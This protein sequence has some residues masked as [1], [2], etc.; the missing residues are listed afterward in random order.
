MNATAL[1]AE[2]VT[3]SRYED[4]PRGGPRRG[5]AR[6][7]RLP[8]RDAGRLRRAGGPHPPAGGPRRRAAPRSA[9]VVGTGRRTGAVWAALCQRHRGPRARLRRHQLRPD[10]PSLGAGAGGGAGR[11]RAGAG[12]RARGARTPSCWASRSRPRWPRSSTR[13]HYEHGWHATCT[14]GTLG[15]AAAAARLLGLDGGADASRPRGGRLAVLGAQGKLR[16][17]DQALP[18]RPR[19]AERRA[20]RR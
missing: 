18:R 16:H 5:P 11:G 4:C 13:P 14:L 1:L 15:A 17:H 10:G 19:R 2:F 9:T 3:K 8:G 12:R 6:H 7:P 20:R